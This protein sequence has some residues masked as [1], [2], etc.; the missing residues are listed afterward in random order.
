MS[1]RR[2]ERMYEA[3]DLIVREAVEEVLPKCD[4]NPKGMNHLPLGMHHCPKCGTM[5]TASL[6]HPPVDVD[7]YVSMKILEARAKWELGG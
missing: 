4:Y 6:K 7:S 2:Y 3:V 1:K 5:V